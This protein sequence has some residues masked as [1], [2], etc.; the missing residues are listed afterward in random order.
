M[1]NSARGPALPLPREDS[2][3]DPVAAH[4]EKLE[5]LLRAIVGVSCIL[6]PLL[7]Q[8]GVHSPAR[9]AAVLILF[10]LAPGSA[11]LPV[12]SRRRFGHELGLVLGTSL[13]VS[14]LVAQAMLWVGGWSPSAATWALGCAC[15]ASIAVQLAMGLPARIG[16]VADGDGNG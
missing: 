8:L 16:D 11:L 14:A 1:V 12:L 2:V 4:R 9:T 3:D 10:G 5:F 13:A 7:M 15:L 6:A